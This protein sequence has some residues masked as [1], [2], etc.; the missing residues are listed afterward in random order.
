[1]A[2]AVAKGGLRMKTWWCNG[3]MKLW[4]KTLPTTCK[5]SAEDRAAKSSSYATEFARKTGHQL[6][7]LKLDFEADQQQKMRAQAAPAVAADDD[8]LAA[9]SFCGI[10]SMAN[11][12]CAATIEKYFAEELGYAR[13]LM[14]GIQR[15]ADEVRTAAID[16]PKSVLCP[17]I[18]ERD[19]TPGFDSKKSLEYKVSIKKKGPKTCF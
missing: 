11:P 13:D 7:S 18:R 8:S 15:V 19:R 10:G 12:V 4:R 3:Q 1:M 6:E 17:V 16:N 5:L 14:P 2:K 9:W